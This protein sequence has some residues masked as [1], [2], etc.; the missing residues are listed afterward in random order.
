MSSKADRIDPLALTRQTVPF[1]PI[2]PFLGR[3]QHWLLLRQF[4]IDS[5]V[6]ENGSEDFGPILEE[7]RQYLRPSNNAVR[8]LLLI[9]TN[10]DRMTRTLAELVHQEDYFRAKPSSITFIRQQPRLGSL[11]L[12]V[13]KTGIE[14]STASNLRV[15]PPEDNDDI[16]RW[17]RSVMNQVHEPSIVIWD[18][19]DLVDHLESGDPWF[20]LTSPLPVKV[21]HILSASP[22]ELTSAW[23][24]RG[25]EALSLKP[26]TTME[27]SPPSF[28]PL[29]AEILQ[30]LRSSRGG[31]TSDEVAEILPDANDAAITDA[32]V[33]MSQFVGIND[34]KRWFLKEKKD[35]IIRADDFERIGEWLKGKPEESDTWL[36]EYPPLLARLERWDELAEIFSRPTTVW[37]W[38]NHYR[39]DIVDLAQLLTETSDRAFKQIA[40]QARLIEDFRPHHALA[41]AALLMATNEH[42]SALDHLRAITETRMDSDH[43]LHLLVAKRRAVECA[44]HLKDLNLAWELLQSLEGEVPL[45][46]DFRTRGQLKLL[47][48]E[49]LIE[50]KEWH[51]ANATLQEVE[52]E[53]QKA[54]QPW[55]EVEALRLQAETAAAESDTAAL[56]TIDS[57]MLAHARAHGWD[58]VHLAPLRRETQRKVASEDWESAR[59][60]SLQLQE[61]AARLAEIDALGEALGILAMLENREGHYREMSTI[62]AAK[63]R[64]CREVGDLPGVIDLLLSRAVAVGF[65]LGDRDSARSLAQEALRWG[66]ELN[67]EDRQ[68]K[69]K[70]VL[71]R[72]NADS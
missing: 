47:A 36:W 57:K 17:F 5:I 14:L 25:M 32:L 50:R 26:I 38:W 12:L 49:L 40:D 41:Y 59:R 37:R 2:D 19:I 16:Y 15:P 61:I 64:L 6:R 1:I 18:G 58:F 21:R 63:E 43:R 33:G 11:P 69:A 28:T 70:Q 10:R 54:G 23:Q 35:S 42:A 68:L 62:L 45:S 3:N 53:A 52:E 8:P 56:S 30:L 29:Q 22:G 46:A 39:A 7:I 72:L 27:T 55:F 13:R 51:Q 9:E 48:S 4:L 60:L 65:R 34:Q 44:R 20:W 67:D 24:A 66:V 71:E 31:R